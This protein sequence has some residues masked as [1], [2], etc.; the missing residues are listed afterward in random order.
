MV[1]CGRWGIGEGWCMQALGETVDEELS[2]V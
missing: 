2:E 1:V